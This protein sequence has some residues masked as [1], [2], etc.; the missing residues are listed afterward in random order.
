M[1][2][3]EVFDG[4]YRD[5]SKL[6]QK[7]ETVFRLEDGQGQDLTPEEFVEYYLQ[8]TGKISGTNQK[9]I[10]NVLQSSGKEIGFV[11]PP[12]RSKFKYFA[13]SGELT[14]FLVRLYLSQKDLEYAFFEDFVQSLEKDYGIYIRKDKKSEKLLAKY[15]IRVTQQEVSRNEQA[16][17]NTLDHVNCLVRL[18]DSGYVVTLPEKKGDF[19]LL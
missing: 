10:F 11:H 16:F 5:D 8:L 4:N 7:A 1:Y 6:N 19:R 12:S 18:S 13:M 14:A 3:N 17:L 2:A 9:R 15:G